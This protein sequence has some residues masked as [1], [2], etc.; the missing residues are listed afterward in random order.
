MTAAAAAA[1]GRA[2]RHH[3]RVV[4]GGRVVGAEVVLVAGAER[5]VASA[6]SRTRLESATTTVRIKRH[7]SRGEVLHFVRQIGGAHVMS[8]G[9]L[10]IERGGSGDSIY[11]WTDSNTTINGKSS[12]QEAI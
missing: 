7:E 8:G 12:K 2:G 4:V 9:F 1:A 10:S 3:R 5:G 11:K 6:R